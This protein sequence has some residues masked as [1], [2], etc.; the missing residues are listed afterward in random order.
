MT[1]LTREQIIKRAAQAIVAAGFDRS[2]LPIE[3]TEKWA[4]AATDSVLRLMADDLERKA[5]SD[6]DM[7]CSCEKCIEQTG[8][9]IAAALLRSLLPSTEGDQP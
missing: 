3:N 4:A 1:G 5:D 8:V 9:L 6:H 2:V 7:N